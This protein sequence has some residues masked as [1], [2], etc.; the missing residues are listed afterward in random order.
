MRPAKKG[1]GS[2]EDG[3]MF[4][5]SFNIVVHPRCVNLAKELASYAYKTDRHTGEILPIPED[6]NN[7][8]VDALRYAVERLHL[9]GKLLPEMEPD[10]SDRL[11]RPND[12]YA[13]RDEDADSW[14]VV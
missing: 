14:K 12:E 11:R 8:W 3:I 10:E 13:A 9:K 6:A 5:Q 1:P 7:H 2:V 4:L